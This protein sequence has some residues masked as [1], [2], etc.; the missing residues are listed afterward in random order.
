MLGIYA[1]LRPLER[2]RK[3]LSF[4]SV[5]QFLDVLMSSRSTQIAL[6][7]GWSHDLLMTTVYG[8]YLSN[9][10]KILE[11]VNDVGESPELRYIYTYHINLVPK[12]DLEVMRDDIE[13]RLIT[14][15]EKR[16]RRHG[17]I[18][19]MNNR[20]EVE[21]TYNTLRSSREY[22][23]LPSLHTFRKLSVVAMLQ[24]SVSSDTGNI[25]ETF[26][27]DKRMKDLLHSQLK[28]W[29]DKAK[30]DLGALLGFP[31]NWKN[32][33]KKVFHPA[34]RL[35]ARYLCTQCERFNEKYRV[36]ECFDFAGACS[37]ECGE[38]IG[39]KAPKAKKGKK[40]VWKSENFVKD[41]KV[42]PN[43]VV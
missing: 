41:E 42:G 19:L 17:E 35:S 39:K 25:S 33:S 32:A 15:D 21:K 9:K 23:Y 5:L 34:E 2:T 24:S 27:N 4:P 3:G 37:H 40:A 13:A 43:C 28:T 8:P 7:N 1:T 11:E 31:K 16:D 10:T 29:T 18:T 6:E 14:L 12:S 22:P 20:K 38:G 30:N 26:K 36:D